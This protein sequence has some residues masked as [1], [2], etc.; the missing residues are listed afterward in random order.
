MFC[1]WLCSIP[2]YTNRAPAETFQQ[3][4]RDLRKRQTPAPSPAA[5][6]E[7]PQGTLDVMIS[8]SSPAVTQHAIHQ[9]RRL[10]RFYSGPF[11]KSPHS[12]WGWGSNVDTP[13]RKLEGSHNTTAGM[14]NKEHSR[15]N[16]LGATFYTPAAED[17][18]RKVQIFFTRIPSI[19]R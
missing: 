18:W 7:Q 9:V 6:T 12:R 13:E 4:Y 19:R 11:R 5:Q 3:L 1:G 8:A 14:W 16:F 15:R 17:M 10:S 2:V